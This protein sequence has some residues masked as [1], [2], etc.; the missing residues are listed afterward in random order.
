MCY[1]HM[2][3]DHMLHMAAHAHVYAMGGPGRREWTFFLGVGG[4]G[5]DGCSDGVMEAFG[6]G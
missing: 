5:D 2:C 4:R 3:Y 1:L 6:L